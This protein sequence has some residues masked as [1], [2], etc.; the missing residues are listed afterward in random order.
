MENSALTFTATPQQLTLNLSELTGCNPSFD[1]FKTNKKRI[2]G[3]NTEAYA[4]EWQEAYDLYGLDWLKK[5]ADFR[6]AISQDDE[7]FDLTAALDNI[8]AEHFKY[9]YE[10][11]DKNY[12]V[13]ILIG[14]KNTELQFERIHCVILLASSKIDRCA[15]PLI[16][17]YVKNLDG[18][19]TNAVFM[20]YF[21][22]V[23][24]EIQK[25]TLPRKI[26]MQNKIRR[27]C[28]SQVFGTEYSDS[29]LWGYLRN[30]GTSPV[31]FVQPLIRKIYTDIIPKLALTQNSVNFIH[32]VIRKQ[33]QYLFH[34]KIPLSYETVNS[35]IEPDEAS[36]FDIESPKLSQN[37]IY[38]PL[39]KLG[40][41][42]MFRKIKHSLALNITVSNEE[43]NRYLG[44]IK[45]T[46]EKTLLYLIL[47][48]KF[49]E[50][51]EIL[52]TVSNKNFTI[53][54]LYLYKILLN[55]GFNELSK[56]ILSDQYESEMS[57]AKFRLTK[58]YLTLIK[59]SEKYSILR[60]NRFKDVSSRFEKNNV[61]FTLL[62][63]C[64]RGSRCE[65]GTNEDPIPVI[66]DPDILADELV[67]LIGLMSN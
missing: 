9:A 42:D 43:V 55:S 40:I 32:V 21:I 10:Y 36:V 34:S 17:E 12:D 1:V 53:L 63:S 29:V 4:D 8:L 50:E 18:D 39:I 13:E 33:L 48:G 41:E 54:M 37:E 46:K 35:A 2:Y 15:I 19:A 67:K 30:T 25:L 61:I 51:H 28:E 20:N 60:D 65:L 14:A 59:T 56:V 26:N 64:L 52:Y 62:E 22:H 44:K 23:M 27:L 57:I 6:T 11:C 31:E 66:I 58:K 5:I 49:I 7:D 24:E 16:S 47:F 38:K 3:K 45:P